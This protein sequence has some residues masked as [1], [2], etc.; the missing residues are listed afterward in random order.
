MLLGL[1]VFEEDFGKKKRIE[2]K[3]NS[4]SPAGVLWTEGDKS[5]EKYIPV[6]RNIDGVKYL[7]VPLQFPLSRD[8]SAPLAS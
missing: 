4:K 2:V 6:E 5:A 8:V 3:L 1:G 7:K